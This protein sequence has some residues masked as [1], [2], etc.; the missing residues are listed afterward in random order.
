MSGQLLALFYA[1]GTTLKPIG[2]GAVALTALELVLV[3]L[4][5]GSTE[6][7]QLSAFNDQGFFPER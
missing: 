6:S 2:A 1:T 7:F 5:A 3:G 4:N